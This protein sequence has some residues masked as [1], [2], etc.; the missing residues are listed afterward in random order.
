M[1]ELSAKIDEKCQVESLSQKT[2]SLSLENCS[3]SLELNDFCCLVCFS[4]KSGSDLTSYPLKCKESNE[5]G[6]ITNYTQ[7]TF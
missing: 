5:F 7:S 4:P 2:K 6:G 1:V 3:A